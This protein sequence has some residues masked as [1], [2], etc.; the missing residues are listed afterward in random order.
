[1]KVKNLF[2]LVLTAAFAVSCENPSVEVVTPQ[3]NNITFEECIDVSNYVPPARFSVEFTNEGVNITHYLL[4]VNCMFNNVLINSTFDNRVLNITEL[5]EP[6]SIAN[7]ICYTNVSYTIN[8]ISKNDID[9]ILINGE[10]AWSA[11]QSADNA[12]VGKWHTEDRHA[13]D[14]DTIVFTEDFRVQKYFDYISANQV[15]PAMYL[16]PFVTYSPSDNNS[17]TFT[18]H[19]FY[20]SVKNFDETFEYILNDD[21]LTIKCFSN[22]FSLTLEAKN[23][24][25]S[26]KI[27]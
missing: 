12:L 2:F 9:T 14:N 17:I 24:I 16:C 21:L 10:V 11:S 20:P 5:D 13:G 4:Q 25:N 6:N 3:V 23:N 27:E 7:C 18:I 15:T 26:K 22:P 8:G 1:M 19:Y